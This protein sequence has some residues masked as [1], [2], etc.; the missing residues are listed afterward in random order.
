MDAVSKLRN[1]EGHVI[2]NGVANWYRVA[3]AEHA[4]T[5]LVVIH[6]GPGGDNYNFERT[7]GRRLE[8]F[9]TVIYHEQRGSGRSAL[10]ADSRAYSID[11]LT[12]DLEEL[13]QALGLSQIIPLGFS[14]GGQL[15]LEYTL[16][17]AGSVD[18]L[19]LEAP[20]VS[21]DE[22]LP[23]VQLNG[24]RQIAT[25]SAAK[26]IEG[27]LAADGSFWD[28]LD[29]VWDAVDTPTVDRLLF[30]NAEVATM[31]RQMWDES[32]LV[33]TGDMMKALRNQPPREPLIERLHSIQVPTLV[34]GGLYDRN[35]GVDTFREVA[36]RIPDTRFEL[37]EQSAH[38]PDMEEESKYAQVVKTFLGL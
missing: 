12:S 10:P 6:G 14:F 5:P 24:F 2:L 16:A 19:I 30:H 34:I 29:K 17:H 36:R 21:L 26:T 4:T 11:I 8:M 13:R 33:N 9:T 3:G 22:Q 23:R 20:S 15:A 35:I 32:G 18:R 1:E 28:K 7:I 27:I 37:F 31:N 38:F 25:G